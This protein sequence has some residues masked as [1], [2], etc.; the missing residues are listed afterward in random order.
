MPTVP[1]MAKRAYNSSAWRYHTNRS[2]S[3]PSPRGSNPKSPGSEPSRWA[4]ASDPGAQAASRAVT[5]STVRPVAQVVEGVTRTLLE[6]N[7]EVEAET[8]AT[9]FAL[10]ER[11]TVPAKV[12]V[13]RID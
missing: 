3:L 6:R 1:S 5:E 7:G 11:S 12:G 10:V 2:G 9:L 13:V 8:A 4:G